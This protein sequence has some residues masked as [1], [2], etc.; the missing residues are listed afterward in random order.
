MEFSG[1][2]ANYNQC[3]NVLQFRIDYQTWKFD[4][5]KEIS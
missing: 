5:R 4:I 3:Q 1:P 2:S